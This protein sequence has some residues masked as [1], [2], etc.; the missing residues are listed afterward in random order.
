[1][2]KEDLKKRYFEDHIPMHI[3][4]KKNQSVFRFNC[5]SGFFIVPSIQYVR[6]KILDMIL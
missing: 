3:A 5:N 1:M 6:N 2:E 4:I